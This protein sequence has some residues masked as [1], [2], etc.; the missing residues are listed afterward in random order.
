MT[1]RMFFTIL[2]VPSF[3]FGIGFLLAPGLVLDS[4]GVQHSPELK[5]LGRLFGGVL[6]TLG[7]IHW[8]ARDF[9]E[10]AAVRA[11]LAGTVIGSCV[12]MVVALKGT[13][14]GATNALGWSTAL[15]Y[16]F[17]AVG[18]VYFLR[19]RTAQLAHT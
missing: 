13:L 15:I 6:L 11:A 14:F 17:A 12:N 7:V 19:A 8:L 2:A 3:L 4:Y 18:S 5:L 16:F 9:I 10:E 1:I